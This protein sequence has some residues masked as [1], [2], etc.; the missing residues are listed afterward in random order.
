MKKT[1]TTQQQR[2]EQPKFKKDGE[3]FFFNIFIG[4]PL[5]YNGALASAV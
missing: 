4:V 5:L 3:T 2:D 1:L